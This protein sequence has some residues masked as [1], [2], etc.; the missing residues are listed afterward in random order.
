M[1]FSIK[2]GSGSVIFSLETDS[3]GLCVG[4]A[5][6]GDADLRYA[7]LSNA[8]LRNADLG[9][10]DL[11]NADLSNADLS[12]ANLRYAYLRYADLSNANLGDADLSNADLSN[13]DL[14]NANLYGADLSNATLSNATLSNATLRNANLKF[15]ATTRL[16]TGE[17]WAEYLSDVV[18]ALCTAGGHTLEEVAAH[19]DCHD[20][21]NCPMAV[22]FDCH[23]LEGVPFLH[24]PRAERFV[25]LFDA[26]LIPSPLGE[27]VVNAGA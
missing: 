6:K 13:A 23:N 16:E 2:S 19:W 8:D 21:A 26:H 25:A 3:M 7:D 15:D 11:S 1:L 12:N 22:A 18:P 20:W 4:A 5:V 14:S 17:T 10:A 9:D 27:A 24:R